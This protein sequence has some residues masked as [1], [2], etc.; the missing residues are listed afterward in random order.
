MGWSYVSEHLFSPS[1][2]QPGDALRIKQ[3]AQRINALFS[4]LEPLV[5]GHP[6]F[7]TAAKEF[8]RVYDDQY[9]LLSQVSSGSQEDFLARIL[10][11]ARRVRQAGARVTLARDNLRIE[12]D[13]LNR[14][15]LEQE[16]AR[17]DIKFQI[18]AGIVAEVLLTLLVV[19]LFLRSI[20][21]RLKL[22]MANAAMIPT[23]QALERRV[24]G[25]DELAQ[26]DK[27]LHDA[28]Q[29]LRAASE[30]RLALMDML[31]HD[32][33]SPLNAADL[34]IGNMLKE[35][36][37]RTSIDRER[38]GNLKETVRK[39][40]QLSE[41]LLTADKLEAGLLPPERT[42]VELPGVVG[43]AL[44]MVA[45]LA[46]EKH[47][48]IKPSIAAEAV[49]ADRRRLLQ[50][51]VNLLSN[52]IH[53]SPWQ[54]TVQVCAKPKDNLVRI[55]VQDCGPGIPENERKR[56]F[57]KFY[58]GETGSS[59]RGFGLGLAIC[60]MLVEQHHGQ[61]GVDSEIGKG[62]SFWFTLPSAADEEPDEERE[63]S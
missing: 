17:A 31:A 38:L 20:G 2:G 41:D 52:A 23:A 19:G 56:I 40:L 29:Q 6:G 35:G 48:E 28:A 9:A 15:R 49:L 32:I 5:V 12:I 53:F 10:P 59:K 33:R 51:L 24:P 27:I 8:H 37:S 58:Q 21:D 57:S 55:E 1:T 60:K 44:K 13:I 22:L 54:G 34:A 36:S 7:A 14:A 16:R 39:L 30:S 43:E 4:E 18:L 3:Y 26:L 45:P 62:S 46:A 63:P 50:I 42:V 47:L 61:I 11:V 25:F